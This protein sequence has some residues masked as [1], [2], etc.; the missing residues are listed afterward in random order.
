MVCAKSEQRQ[1]I[2]LE[3]MSFQGTEAGEVPEQKFP[4][5]AC[6]YMLLCY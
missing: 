4:L 2:Q 6:A 3:E 5:L 1:A